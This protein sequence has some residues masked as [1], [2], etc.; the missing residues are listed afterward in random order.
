MSQSNVTK[1][2]I[3]D[4]IID[5]DWNCRDQIVPSDVAD[6][7]KQIKQMGLIQPVTLMRMSDGS[8]KL[9]AGYR[10]VHAHKML[11]LETID[12]IIRD[13]LTEIDAS[14]INLAENIERKNLTP[15]E[16]ARTLNRLLSRGYMPEEIGEKLNRSAFW[17]QSRLSI[18]K[19]PPAV[20]QEVA[21]GSINLKQVRELVGLR[22]DIMYAKIRAIKER[23]QS[24]ESVKALRNIEKKKKQMQRMSKGKVRSKKEMSRVRN[25]L[26][27][28]FGGDN[29]ELTVLSW[30]EGLITFERVE[31]A[32]KKQCDLFEIDYRTI[33][34]IENV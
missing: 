13:D 19:L 18:L 9:V 24:L 17:V 34:D 10:R 20:Q 2:P 16:E 11:R 3:A 21:A 6:L 31:D 1:V 28:L 32:V 14:A 26:Y 25:Y 8:L 23:K 33:E 5:D 27:T 4:I 30:A 29:I 15:L 22:E 7:A 12:A